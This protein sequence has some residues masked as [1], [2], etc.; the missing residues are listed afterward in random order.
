[1]ASLLSLPICGI[2]VTIACYMVGLAIGKR[3]P[4][5]LTSPMVTANALIILVV[6]FTPL[7]LE[8]YQA[9]GNMIS[10]FV[11]PVT[12]IL[13]LRIYSQRAR[14]KEN[15]IPILGGC[16]AGSSVSLLS[17]WML[18]RLFGIDRVIALSIM[19]KSVTVA[20]AIELSRRGGG[21]AGLAVS[22]VIVTGITSSSFMPFF[23][24]IF[25]LKDPV[26]AGVAMGCSGH[27]IGTA[28]AIELGETQGAISGLSMSIMAIVTS[29]IYL[30]L[31]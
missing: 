7:T 30:F 31:F 4:T 19:P 28:A 1:M 9:G 21:F 15:I 25:R 17:V 14:L 23:I 3:I 20:I 8:Q 24:K 2:L 10:M 26:A 11:G 18:C 6:V 13:A 16:I 12:V 27:A 22:A 29:I 5:P